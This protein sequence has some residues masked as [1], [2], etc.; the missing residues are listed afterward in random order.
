MSVQIPAPLLSSSPL[1]GRSLLSVKTDG[2]CLILKGVALGN[3]TR[4]DIRIWGWDEKEQLIPI[5]PKVPFSAA[6][7][8]QIEQIV[9]NIFSHYEDPSQ[10]EIL[11]RRKPQEMCLEDKGKTNLLKEAQKG[12]EG[13]TEIVEGIRRIYEFYNPSHP[14][15]EWGNG[16]PL[17]IYPELE[18]APESSLAAGT[19]S[20]VGTPSSSVDRATSTDA[21]GKTLPSEEQV[22]KTLDEASAEFGKNNPESFL[23]G[24]TYKQLYEYALQGT[25]KPE[26]E[27]YPKYE[28]FTKLA[29]NPEITAVA[30]EKERQ[31]MEEMKRWLH[32]LYKNA[33]KLYQQYENYFDDHV[34]TNL[35]HPWKGTF[36]EW[37]RYYAVNKVV[38]FIY[39]KDLRI[40]PLSNALMA[41][42]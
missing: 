6:T 7:L 35:D 29:K 19:S 5:D 32:F 40:D 12:N 16:I 20:S 26:D 23:H 34:C 1:S 17:V 33:Y 38:G 13:Y 10:V 22:V 37:C 41:I 39:V 15:I 11:Y 2:E 24:M 25:K 18:K 30:D 3:G 31:K 4:W 8:N 9:A 14:T 21:A 27:L 28:I 36:V 42:E